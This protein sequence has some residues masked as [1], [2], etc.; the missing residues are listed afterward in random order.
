MS[1]KRTVTY[2]VE[3]AGHEIAC[4]LTL[5]EASTWLEGHPHRV[6]VRVTRE[7]IQPMRNTERKP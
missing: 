3:D 5:P 2:A 7:P 1:A 6:I 4:K